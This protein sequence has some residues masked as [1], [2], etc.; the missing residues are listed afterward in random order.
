[1][2]RYIILNKK[3][4]GGGMAKMDV[5]LGPFILILTFHPQIENVF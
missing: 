4:L 1:M 2:R 3:C 5:I